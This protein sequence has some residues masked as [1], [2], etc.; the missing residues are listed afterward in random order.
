ME[1][2]LRPEIRQVLQRDICEQLDSYA[3]DL[4]KFNR[5][6]N[7]VSRRGVELRVRDL[8]EESALAATRISIKTYQYIV[9]VGSGA[10]VPGIP[11]AMFHPGCRMVLVERRSGR[12]DF[13][14]REVAVLGLANVRIR[15]G[16]AR[17][18]VKDP[19]LAGAFHWAL[20]KAVAAPRE[21][22]E[23]ARPFLTTGG[24]AALFRSGS[25]NPEEVVGE[26]SW[27]LVDTIGLAPLRTVVFVFRPG[28]AAA[29]LS[30]ETPGAP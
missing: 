26:D 9:D 18:L 12:C 11:F 10:G 24:R 16:D 7:L 15:E 4:I 8:L 29:G 14:R 17:G 30:Q 13:L 20:L 28:A 27:E 25:W 19:R 22:L 1:S 3:K 5:G 2:I 21:A 6:Q 23:L